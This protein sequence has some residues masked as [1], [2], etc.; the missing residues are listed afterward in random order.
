MLLTIPD[1]LSAE[2]VASARELLDHAEWV[3]GKVT[4]GPQSARAKRNQQL[5]EG[6]RRR[7][8]ARRHDPDRAAA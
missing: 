3:D 7:R 2:Q 4:A 8:N 1:L 5:L 6:F